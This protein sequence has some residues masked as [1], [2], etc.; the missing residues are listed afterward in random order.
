MWQGLIIALLVDLIIFC[1]Q[2]LLFCE[3]TRFTEA[4]HKA[5]MEVARKKGLPVLKHHLLPR[6]KGFVLSVNGL[7]GTG[8]CMM[9]RFVFNLCH[10]DASM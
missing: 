1:P 7:K 8:I 4:K 3:G 5:S 9:C 10:R 2:L 6:T